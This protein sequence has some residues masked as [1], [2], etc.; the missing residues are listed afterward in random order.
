MSFF[1]LNILLER[2]RKNQQGDSNFRGNGRRSER[3]KEEL[4]ST[5][6]I[7]QKKKKK[8]KE[9][10]NVYWTYPQI[11]RFSNLTAILSVA[12][13]LDANLWKR[14]RKKMEKAIETQDCCLNNCSRVAVV[15]E[16]N[17]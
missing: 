10:T 17:K 14:P 6:K 13:F 8:K 11:I 3:K 15:T 12:F 7:S 9:T 4:K 1:F 5:T 16:R 2:K